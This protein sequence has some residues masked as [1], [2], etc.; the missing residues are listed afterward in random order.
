MRKMLLVLL[1]LMM[2]L[3]TTINPVMADGDYS[4]SFNASENIEDENTPESPKKK[5]SNGVF[6]YLAGFAALATA[7]YLFKQNQRK[8]EITLSVDSVESNGDGSYIVSFGYDN[9]DSTISFDDGDY[10][11]RVLKGNAIL[12][13]RPPSNQFTNGR[14]KNEMIVA[15]NEE[16]E[17]EYYV[18]NKKIYI[19]GREIIEKE[20]NE[21]DETC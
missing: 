14:H 1:I 17:I 18:G 9:P 6:I 5:N 8:L 20:E 10:G 19:K 3:F 11:L 16:S 21:R 7:A 13:K 4:S 2:T 12:L 15:I